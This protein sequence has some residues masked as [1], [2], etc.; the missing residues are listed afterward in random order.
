M[1]TNEQT[2]DAGQAKSLDAW[3]FRL[4]KG[5]RRGSLSEEFQ[6]GLAW[7]HPSGST[8]GAL[9]LKKNGPYLEAW[10]N[11]AVADAALG[12]KYEVVD[13]TPPELAAVMG[14]LE[15][16][17]SR[18]FGK[19]IGRPAAEDGLADPRAA[20]SVQPAEEPKKHEVVVKEE[21]ALPVPPAVVEESARIAEIT[22]PPVIQDIIPAL[23]A[24]LA[25]PEATKTESGG[26]S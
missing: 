5:P 18:L 3:R 22:V 23:T 19:D 12:M 1:Q 6:A 11:V 10:T 17:L 13:P 9:V 14:R 8:T 7:R 24:A 26:G 25:E 4:I 2:R 15:P 21:P 20:M 16:V